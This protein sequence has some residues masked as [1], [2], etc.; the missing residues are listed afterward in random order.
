MMLFSRTDLPEDANVETVDVINATIKRLHIRKISSLSY[1]DQNM[2][3]WSSTW[4][5]VY[6]QAH[7][8]R[9]LSL[10]EGGLSAL[11]GKRPLVTALCA[12]GLMEDA[13]AIWDFIERLNTLLDKGE[14][15]ST[16]EFVL[17]RTLSTKLDY[18]LKQFG[19]EFAA[20]NVLTLIDR[21]TKLNPGYRLVYN[22]LSEVVHPNSL[23][24]FQHFADLDEANGRIVFHDA[25]PMHDVSLSALIQA[26]HM[27]TADEPAIEALEKRMNWT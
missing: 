14:E 11:E 25:E 21:I 13:A 17:T 6:I 7:I 27:L 3:E 23:G 12:R 16:E 10:I 20:V 9:S 15:D 1:A 24:V 26:A 18:Q 8:R 2:A 22:D 19:A 5:R 4:A